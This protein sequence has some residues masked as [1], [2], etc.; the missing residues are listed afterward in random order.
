MSP[1]LCRCS[2][3]LSLSMSCSF[4]YSHM[5]DQFLFKGALFRHVCRAAGKPL[6]DATGLVR[7][8]FETNPHSGVCARKMGPSCL[9][10]LLFVD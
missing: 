6:Q 8:L 10:V 5:F 2:H 7:V 1:Y 4:P 3:F 9:R